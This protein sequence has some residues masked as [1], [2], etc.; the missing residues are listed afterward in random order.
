MQ[1]Y[2]TYPPP[3]VVSIFNDT[4]LTGFDDSASIIADDPTLNDVQV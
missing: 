3:K 2:K 4:S 1:A